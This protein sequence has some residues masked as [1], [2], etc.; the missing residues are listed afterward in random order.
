VL[1][2]P[3]PQWSSADPPAF[4][5]VQR[6]RMVSQR[7]LAK[8][9]C[10][11]TTIRAGE[12]DGNPNTEADP[13]FLRFIPTPCFPSYPSDL[14][15]ATNGGTEVL[16]RLY[17]ESGHSITLTNSAVPSIVLQYTTFEQIDDDGDDARVNGG[18]HFRTDQAAGA[19]LGR[20]IG[21]AVYKHNLRPVHD[22][23]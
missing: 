18:I 17:G 3:A 13:T 8:L 15:S 10:P 11:E 9:R 23:E 1:P 2:T 7:V 6:R 12:S 4:S 14:A 16:R 5:S 20:A 22:D 21:T 19:H